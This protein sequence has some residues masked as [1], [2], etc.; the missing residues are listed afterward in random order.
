[1]GGVSIFISCNLSIVFALVIHNGC[2]HPF[3]AEAMVFNLLFEKA[4]KFQIEGFHFH[5][6]EANDFK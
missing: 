3:D 1:V 6:H 2:V 4:Y 5:H